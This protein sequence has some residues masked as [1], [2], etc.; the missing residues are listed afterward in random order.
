MVF[1][2]SLGHEECS[3]NLAIAVTTGHQSQDFDLALGH[4]FMRRGTRGS[5]LQ[6]AEPAQYSVG[7]GG[8]NEGA[9]VGDAP[10]RVGQL[11]EGNVLQQVAFRSELVQEGLQ[12]TIPR[13]GMV[14][15]NLSCKRSCKGCTD[16]LNQAVAVKPS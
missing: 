2:G 11:L 6:L 16:Q 5:T 13:L 9:V 4:F 10:N 7:D 12:A 15:C 1:D 8:L 14:A 3:S